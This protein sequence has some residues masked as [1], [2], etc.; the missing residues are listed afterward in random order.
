M[1]THFS[2]KRETNGSLVLVLVERIQGGLLSPAEWNVLELLALAQ[3]S[4]HGRQL[5]FSANGGE[6]LHSFERHVISN[7]LKSE[8]QI[9]KSVIQ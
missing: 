4:Q 2:L 1:V 9:T 6:V 3:Q 7:K 8:F 5:L